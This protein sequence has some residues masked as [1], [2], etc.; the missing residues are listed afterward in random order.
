MNAYLTADGQLLIPA[1]VTLDDGSVGDG[2][3][4]IGTDHPDFAAW[5]EDALPMPT[6]QQPP[7]AG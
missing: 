4:P 5:L 2:L 6:P 3:V 1:R 7:A